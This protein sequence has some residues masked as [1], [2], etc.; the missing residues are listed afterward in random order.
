VLSYPEF[1]RPTGSS[2]NQPTEQYS[3]CS[4]VEFP[5]KG[6]IRFLRS[7]HVHG[8]D[9]IVASPGKETGIGRD[10]A[11]PI[12]AIGVL[13]LG[14]LLPIGAGPLTDKAVSLLASSVEGPSKIVTLV[15]NGQPEALHTRA[16]TVND[17]FHEQL[18]ERTAADVLDVDPSAPLTDGETIHYRAAVTVTLVVDDI[19]QTVRTTADT[20]GSMLKREHVAFDRHD[21]LSPAPSETIANEQTIHLDHVN[22]WVETARHAIAPPV[23]HRMSWNLALGR[24]KVVQRGAPGIREISYLVTRKSADRSHTKRSILVE[25]ILRQPRTRVVAAGIGEYSALAA[26]AKRGFDG[27]ISFAKAAITMVA[28]AY[29]ANCSGCS[30]TTAS[31]Q[32]AG[33]GI[34]AVDPRVI[35]LGSHLYIP[36]YGHA[37]AGDTGGAIRGNRVDLGFNNDADAMQFGRRPVTVYVLHP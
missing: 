2:A 31:G 37:I 3:A 21:Q 29:T 12:A 11:S 13:S 24:T 20:I 17:L 35:P 16:A 33:H 7:S 10:S 34:V 4:L 15:R 32:H 36:G 22:S 26:L 28:T 9:P 30:G 14:L 27:T 5:L 18:I 23:K 8:R 25:R 1:V 6:F 19:P